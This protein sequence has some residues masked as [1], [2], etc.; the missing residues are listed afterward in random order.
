[1]QGELLRVTP[2]AGFAPA[3]L[4]RSTSCDSE[5][6]LSHQ[7]LRFMICAYNITSNIAPFQPA[8]LQTIYTTTTFKV[9]PFQ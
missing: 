7:G 2:V 4:R 3:E 6:A 5:H 8:Y 9:L 1:M